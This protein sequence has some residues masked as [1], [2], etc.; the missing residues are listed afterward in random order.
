MNKQRYEGHHSI[1][2]LLRDIYHATDNEDIQ[3]KC[4]ECVTMA[5]VMHEKLKY[6]RAKACGQSVEAQV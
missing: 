5:K 6:W 1:C 2:Q 4:R 3:L